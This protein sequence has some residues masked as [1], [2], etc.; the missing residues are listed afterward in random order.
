MD[1]INLYLYRNLI[2]FINKLLSVNILL[3]NRENTIFQG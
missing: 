2:I 3:K 1:C